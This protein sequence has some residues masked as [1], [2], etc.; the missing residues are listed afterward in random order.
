MNLHAYLAKLNSAGMLK[1]GISCGV[2]P[3]HYLKYYEIKK[4]YEQMKS[5]KPDV[6][7]REI[8]YDLS[9]KYRVSWNYVYRIISL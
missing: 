4:E 1:S 6:K 3:P 8:I 2:I 7:N 9:D 5:L